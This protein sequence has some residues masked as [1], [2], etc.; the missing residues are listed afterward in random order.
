[1]RP[2]HRSAL[3][4]LAAKRGEKGFSSVL[5]EVIDTY[6]AGEG[7]RERKKRALLSLEG[8]LTE[9]EAEELRQTTQR[10]RQEWR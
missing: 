1:M 7:E 4:A 5:E 3:L 9:A 6:L 10:M 8:C 2:D